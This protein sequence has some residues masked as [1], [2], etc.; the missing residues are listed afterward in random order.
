MEINCGLFSVSKRS[1]CTR[2]CI[3]YIFEIGELCIVVA[4][5][6]PGVL[7]VLTTWLG[8][9]PGVLKWTKMN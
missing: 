4:M 2:L 1:T 9:I 5:A 8:R 3:V 7:S 6:K